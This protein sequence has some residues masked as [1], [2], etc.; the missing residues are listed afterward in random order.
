MRCCIW[1]SMIILKQKCSPLLMHNKRRSVIYETNFYT[2]NN[3]V[4]VCFSCYCSNISSYQKD[5][6]RNDYCFLRSSYFVYHTCLKKQL[7]YSFWREQL[8]RKKEKSPNANC[9]RTHFV[10]GDRFYW[11]IHLRFSYNKTVIRHRY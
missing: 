10:F 1:F 4:C 7:C 9:V 3:I 11:R 5:R 8:L 2:S 6:N